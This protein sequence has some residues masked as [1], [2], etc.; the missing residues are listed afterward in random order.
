MAAGERAALYAA[1]ESAGIAASLRNGG[2]R[3]SPH[4]YNTFEEIEEIVDVMASA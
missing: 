3:I 2:V 4:Y 1:V